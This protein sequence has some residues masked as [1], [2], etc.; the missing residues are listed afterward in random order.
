MFY[1][2]NP[3]RNSD[4]RGFGGTGVAPN[5]DYAFKL[6]PAVFPVNVVAVAVNVVALGASASGEVTV[7]PQGYPQPNT[8]MINFKGD[9]GAY[10]GAIVVGV[11][12]G[13]FLITT[14]A[15]CHLI[16]DVT[17]FWTP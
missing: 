1:P 10:N 6:D 2:I 16:C 15:T 13:Q 11:Q 12:N 14:T 3:H 5:A 7:W 8:S 9:G 17:G 4:T